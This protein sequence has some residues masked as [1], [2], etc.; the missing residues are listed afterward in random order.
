MKVRKIK[1]SLEE[2]KAEDSNTY[3]TEYAIR[4]MVANGEISHIR[5]GR[6]ILIDLDELKEYLANGAKQKGLYT[7]VTNHYIMRKVKN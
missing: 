3:L 2:I 6:K 4:Q 1:N 5:R 7:P